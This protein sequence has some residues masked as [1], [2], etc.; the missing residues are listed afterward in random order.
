MNRARVNQAAAVGGEIAGILLV[1]VLGAAQAELRRKGAAMPDAHG[2]N[3]NQAAP[4]SAAT[5]ARVSR[6]TVTQTH[7]PTT[8]ARLNKPGLLVFK[9]SKTFGVGKVR[10]FFRASVSIGRRLSFFS[11]GATAPGASVLSCAAQLCGSAPEPDLIFLY[12]FSWSFF[13]CSAVRLLSVAL[14]EKAEPPALPRGS[15]L[16]RAPRAG[17]LVFGRRR[18]GDGEKRRAEKAGPENAAATCHSAAPLGMEG[19]EHSRMGG[20]LRGCRPGCMHVRRS[21][22]VGVKDACELAR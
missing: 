8:S 15:D 4:T 6:G 13:F 20:G 17:G 12:L 22:G 18:E 14:H 9:S 21:G 16:Q 7:L 10:F 1:R 2:S 11:T 5:P 19:G 3:G